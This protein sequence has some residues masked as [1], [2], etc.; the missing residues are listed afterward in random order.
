VKAYLITFSMNK[1]RAVVEAICRSLPIPCEIV[2]LDLESTKYICVSSSGL[3]KLPQLVL[4]GSDGRVV[5]C[6]PIT[7]PLDV[8]E[9]LEWV[10]RNLGEK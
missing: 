9:I 10:S 6:R 2:E 4:V 7:L 3:I 1:L 8:G 5:G